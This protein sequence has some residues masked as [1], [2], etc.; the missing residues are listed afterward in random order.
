M[1][2]TSSMP[3][4]ILIMDDEEL[5]RLVLEE[6][7]RAEG[8]AVTAV[9]DGRTGLDAL[10]TS[11][12]DCVITDLR[13][14]GVTGWE[15]LRWVRDH[16]PDLDVIVLTGQG[17]VQ[18]AVEAIKAGA[19]D[20]VV[21]ETP[22]DGGPVKAALAKLLAMRTLRQENLALKL[23]ARMP[24]SEPTV[25]G[26][27]RAW[28]KLMETVDRVAPSTAPVLIQGETGSGKEGVAR[29]LH[30][31]SPRRDAPFLA[32][33]CGAVS[34]QLLES[35]LFGHEKGA[36]TGAATAKSGLFA[37]AE[38]G[39]LFLDE[40]GEMSG[41]MQVGLLRVLD[42]GEYRQVGGTRTLRA[43]VRLVAA[44]NRSL[45]DL[46]QAGR[47]REDLLYRINTV[48][49]VVPPLRERPEDLPRLAEH[50][51]S[52]LHVPGRVTRPLSPEALTRLS[53]YP[54]PGNVRELRNVIE[55]LV[56]LSAPDRADPIGAE[57]LA[58]VLQ[59][60]PASPGS[61][62]QETL[63]SLESAERAHILRVLQA[64]GGN[65]TQA[66]R[67]LRIDYKTLLAKLRKYDLPD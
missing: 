58:L 2:G 45:Q 60:M 31:L 55:R 1:T 35:E 5:I 65:K 8:C 33:N 52:R 25:P 49:I 48:T 62:S 63:G 20:Y 53:A 7:L 44:S 38:G 51:L 37:A 32:V 21:K 30:Q 54:W 15:V 3:L 18:S 50:F 64:H 47:F 12:F 11:S 17:E 46:V 61:A 9:A 13:M 67:V 34:D 56:L 24:G 41:P 28:K 14:P 29:T 36:F 16:Q 43:N 39:T 6:S 22:F 26:I 40:I 59:P 66:A 19:C 4:R 23:A 27:S 57:E 10:Q 42:R